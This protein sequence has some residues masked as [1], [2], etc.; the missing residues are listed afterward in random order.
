MLSHVK[1][2]PKH[3]ET[4][5]KAQWPASSSSRCGYGHSNRNRSYDRAARQKNSLQVKPAVVGKIMLDEKRLQQKKPKKATMRYLFAADG[6]QL[7]EG[8][9]FQPFLPFLFTFAF[10]SQRA[11]EH[12]KVH[13]EHRRRRRERFQHIRSIRI[14]NFPALQN[15]CSCG[16]MKN[17]AHAKT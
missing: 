17:C 5:T 15:S 1:A 8:I 6:G 16:D 12:K 3:G 11:H 9:Q 14:E 13:I 2:L 4:N 10:S 7:A